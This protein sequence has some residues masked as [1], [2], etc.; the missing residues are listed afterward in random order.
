MQ[1][2]KKIRFSALILFAIFM[3]NRW[4]LNT[5]QYPVKRWVLILSG[6]FL[7]IAPQI[8]TIYR[9]NG[10]L[11]LNFKTHFY[12]VNSIQIDYYFR[13]SAINRDCLLGFIY[14]SIKMLHFKL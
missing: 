5:K 13:S 3:S 6:Y 1:S 4:A 8:Q 2:Q 12:G 9:I 14:R 10:K 11:Y 7:I